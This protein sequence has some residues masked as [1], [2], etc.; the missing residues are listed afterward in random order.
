MTSRGGKKDHTSNYKNSKNYKRNQQNKNRYQPNMW[1]FLRD[2]II[3]SM[4]KGLI[5]PLFGGLG[6][7]LLLSKMSEEAIDELVFKLLELFTTSYG[8]GIGWIVAVSLAYGW[9]TNSKGLRK[10]HQAEIE[11]LSQEKSDLQRNTLKT[12][13][14]TT[15]K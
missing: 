2:V 5:L 10:L 13:L 3:Q 9:Y 11:R 12:R 7:L 1:G 8:L 6:M 14:S 4:N 15:T